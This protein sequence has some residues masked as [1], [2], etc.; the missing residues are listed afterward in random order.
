LLF[1]DNENFRK[2]LQ[3]RSDDI[4]ATI[5]RLFA[6]SPRT[7]PDVAELQA[8]LTKKLAEEKVTMAELEKTL[9]EKQLLE[10]RLEAASYRYMLAEKK[11]DRARSL[12]VAKLEKQY[13]LGAQKPG[14]DN[15]SVRREDSSSANGAADSTE[16][17]AE[18]E[19]AHNRTVV[20]SDKQKEQLEQ[21]EAE[22]SKLVT[23]ITNLNMK[24][25]LPF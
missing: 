2:H 12:T 8:Q 19:E 13:L 23:Q 3:A 17:I 22:N 16:R 6:S 18:L 20:I 15:S 21:L 24:V 10:E 25:T 9:A 11:I 4:K 14:G 1:A 5:S 7:S